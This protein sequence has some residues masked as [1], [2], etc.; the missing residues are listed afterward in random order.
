MK[1]LL[2]VEGTPSL[3][4][5]NFAMDRDSACQRLRH[6]SHFAGNLPHRPISKAKDLHSQGTG[7]GGVT[8]KM[9][10]LQHLSSSEHTQSK[11]QSGMGLTSA[12]RERNRRRARCV[13][14]ETGRGSE[15][16]KNQPEAAKLHQLRHI[17]AM[18]MKH[19][20]NCIHT[21]SLSLH[22]GKAI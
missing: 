17:L 18:Q 9:E 10:A 11:G 5:D 21:L 15:D 13:E 8:S 7:G 2:R 14:K 6:E 3:R 22:Q 1:G 19:H 4:L 12:W 16:L 20:K